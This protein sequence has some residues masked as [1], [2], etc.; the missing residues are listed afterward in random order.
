M[1][2]P[3]GTSAYRDIE[4]DNLYDILWMQGSYYVFDLFLT[5]KY[6][7]MLME[8]PKLD[9]DIPI[10]LS[11]CGCAIGCHTGRETRRVSGLCMRRWY[12]VR[13]PRPR[14]ATASCFLVRPPVSKGH[15][16]DAQ[17]LRRAQFCAG[18]MH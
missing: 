16:S 13:G 3:I 1:I 6:R 11:I 9:S 7:D 10:M 15:C 17:L 18:H 14:T 12:R 5:K 4:W 2:H 8:I